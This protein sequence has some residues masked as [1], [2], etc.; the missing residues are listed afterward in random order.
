MKFYEFD[1]D[2][3]R[4]D[5]F[6]ERWYKHPTNGKFYRNVTTILG[7]IDK[8]YGF[9]EFL[10]SNGYNADIIVKRAGDFGT[11]FHKMVED[12]LLGGTVSYY[13][14]I[15]L[16][17]SLATA[18][19]ERFSTWIN[20]WE[21]LNREHEVVYK[22]E[23][24]EYIIFNDEHE[25]AG[26]VDLVCKIDGEP[27][28]FDWKTGNNIYPTSKQQLVAYMNPLGIKKGNLVLIPQD[29]INKKGYR[30]TP[31][32]YTDEKFD[33]FV[34]TKKVFDSEN[35]DAPKVLTLPLE[36]KKGELN[37]TNN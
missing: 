32:E 27:Q 15:N 7:V 36:Y 12:Y 29:Y 10:K 33:L 13:D 16:G 6:N 1:K 23:G 26:T 20:F 28:I 35:T 11:I 31:V 25:Y 22:E 8:G 24:V 9:Q 2:E 5:I 34:A 17:D 4:V 18:L 21:E 3:K 30:I 37:E 19:W 14:Y